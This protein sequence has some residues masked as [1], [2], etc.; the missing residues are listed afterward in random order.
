MSVAEPLAE[1]IPEVEE[2][3]E[4][5]DQNEGGEADQ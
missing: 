3:S 4:L 1:A 5:S 2:R